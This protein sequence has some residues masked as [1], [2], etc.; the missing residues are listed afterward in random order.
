MLGIE[1]GL[2]T[3]AVPTG[4]EPVVALVPYH[5]GVFA[6]EA[7][8]ALGPELLVQVEDDLAVGPRAEPVSP[9][10]QLAADALEIVELSVH[11]D[12]DGAVLVGDGLIP[13][14]EIDD[15]QP[16]VAQRHETVIGP[17]VPS[18]VRSSMVQRGGRRPHG[19]RIDG[20]VAR[21]HRGDS[22]HGMS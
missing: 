6:P 22:A 8:Q 20:V 9:A 11:D 3:E 4:D 16:G 13:G 17:P 12:L 18:S 19:L 21:E 2:H 15:R 7:V 14:G 1:E 5:E 10:L